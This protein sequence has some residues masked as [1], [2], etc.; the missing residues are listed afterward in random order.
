MAQ[1]LTIRV[2][3]VTCAA[4]IPGFGTPS[5]TE[6]DV[7]HAIKQAVEI[8]LRDGIE[9][10]AAEVPA[11]AQTERVNFSLR[12][13]EAKSINALAKR[14]GVSPGVVCQRLLLNLASTPVDSSRDALA[15]GVRAG[16]D[17]IPIGCELLQQ[18]WANLPGAKRRVAQAHVY[19]N[20]RGALQGSGVSLIE[21]ATGTGKTI[22]ILLAAEAQLRE[23]P[24]ARVV[25]AVPT[26]S[27]MQ[28]F[29]EAHASLTRTGTMTAS[30][31]AIFGRREFVSQQA[32]CEFMLSSKPEYL[33]HRDAMMRWLS[34][35]GEALPDSPFQA[36]WLAAT[37]RRIAPGLP[38]GEVI[39][40]DDVPED[41]PGWIS[42]TE[43]FN[44]EDREGPE[45]LLC[46][47]AMLSVSTRMRHWNAS[48]DEGVRTMRIREVEL[49]KAIKDAP[50]DLKSDL[51]QDL[52]VLQAERLMLGAIVSENAGKLP[53]FRYLI[54]DEAHALEATMSSANSSYLALNTVAAQARKLAD[55]QLGIT[56]AAYT[57]ITTALA[58][59]KDLAHLAG[60]EP[61]ALRADQSV[62][63][64]AREALTGLLDACAVKR[65]RKVA[66]SAEA[67]GLLKRFEYSRAVLRA[68]VTTSVAAT[69]ATLRFS[70]KRDFPQLHVGA[71]RVD[72]I[73][74]SLWG[75]ARASAC[76]SATLYIPKKPDDGYDY[77]ARYI[78]R[79]LATPADR[80]RDYPPVRPH[81]MYEPITSI[82][83]PA[84]DDRFAPP[85]RSLKLTPAKREEAETQW[86]KAVAGKVINEIRPDAK[87]GILVLMT[88]YD[89]IE[90][91]RPMIPHALLP[92]CVFASPRDSVPEQAA[93]FL[94]F[95]AEGHKP[96]WFATG[97]AWTGLDV[98]G[99]EPMRHLLGREP[100]PADRDNILTDLVIP[101][102]PFGLN[103]SVTHEYRCRT[104]RGTP[105]EV[106]DTLF[107]LKQGIG[108]L[109]RREGLPKNR[110][111]W[112]LDARLYHQTFRFIA[113]RIDLLLKHFTTKAADTPEKAE[114]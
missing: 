109:V 57:R 69:H 100:L 2:P 61:I 54:V 11:S 41:D 89:S 18:A 52:R 67:N 91:I 24:G 25:V 58:R 85:S 43:Q 60:D 46:T 94:G 81:W 3:S 68:A 39:L 31:A 53:P 87:G 33:K 50:E 59:V 98:G 90:K 86:L 97:A 32:L 106:H 5:V 105:W 51:L 110:R 4:L 37:L 7:K 13:A 101:R 8:A 44:H 28:Q 34:C 35:N 77:S 82:T 56:K 84:R 42:Y 62:A 95:A 76:V 92:H 66:L 26:I 47:H 104:D 63:A 80:G 111:I 14:E 38:L 79:I 78:R 99:H 16:D 102:I 15:D 75:S 9:P 19:A 93:A 23:A 29:A 73:M 83:M 71:S 70:P 20:L 96:I 10:L 17:L 55:L 6:L 112:L 36:P 72:S 107:R 65:T 27:L 49:M 114:G 40:A 45:I 113:D 48:R 22:A 1:V 21:A 108:R 12:D 64:A 88:S 103:K 74:Q 30:L